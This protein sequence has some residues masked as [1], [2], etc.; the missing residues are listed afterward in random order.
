MKRRYYLILVL[1]LATLLILFCYLRNSDRNANNIIILQI[2]EH[3]ALNITRKGIEDYLSRCCTQ[4]SISYK[5]AQGNTALALQIGKKIAV[6]HPRLIIALGTVAAQSFLKCDDIPVV[7]SSVTDP[8]SAGL[9]KN[10]QETKTNFTGVSNMISI[11]PQLKLIKDI[12]PNAKK[13]GIIYNSMEIN[14]LEVLRKIKQLAARFDLE[15]VESVIASSN[16]VVMAT[17][18]LANKEVDAIF[19]SNDNTALSAIKGITKISAKFCIPVFC[20]DVDTINSGVLA[21]LGP[22]QYNIGIQTGKIIEKILIDGKMPSQIPVVFPEALEFRI[23]M[24]VAQKLRIAIDQN[25][26]SVASEVI[27]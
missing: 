7:F 13:L 17:Q 3:D 22:D 2:I 12:L 25:I 11:A 6:S 10:L 9:V 21:A 19:V 14:S 4:F 26:L 20:S 16:D 15:I 1:F 5:N 23:N 18:A 8:I 24:K 27:E